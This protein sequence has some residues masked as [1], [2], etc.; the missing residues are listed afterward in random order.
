MVRAPRIKR[1]DVQKLRHWRTQDLVGRRF[2]KLVVLTYA[3]YIKQYG[4]VLWLCQCDCGGRH[5][6][7]ASSLRKGSTTRCPECVHHYNSGR[8]LSLTYRSWN[9][10]K[11]RCLNPKCTHWK[12]YGGRGITVCA[13]WLVKPDGFKNFLADMGKRPNVTMSLDRIEVNGNYEPGNCRWASKSTQ[14]IN[15]RPRTKSAPAA[16]IEDFTDGGTEIY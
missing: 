8:Y 12:N 5:V 13:R 9:S 4:R 14:R 15:Q 16:P 10:M 1:I 2:G 6:V 7:C 3:G 11:S